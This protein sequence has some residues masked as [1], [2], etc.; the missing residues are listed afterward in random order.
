[1]DWMSNFFLKLYLSC[2]FFKNKKL[3]LFK[4]KKGT[5]RKLKNFLIFIKLYFLKCYYF[6]CNFISF[7]V[8]V[9]CF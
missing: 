9:F 2:F 1:M 8:K 6:Y 3:S 5:Q 4:E 7:N